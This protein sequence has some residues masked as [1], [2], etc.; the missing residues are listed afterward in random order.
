MEVP[1]QFEKSEKTVLLFWRLLDDGVKKYL[2]KS[3]RSLSVG[4]GFDPAIFVSDGQG[5]FWT[6]TR[7]HF[8]SGDGT[9]PL[10]GREQTC[11]FHFTQGANRLEN[12]FKDANAEVLG[13]QFKT[14]ALDCIDTLDV[15][16]TIEKFNRYACQTAACL[17]M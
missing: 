13:K 8:G 7:K 12:A 6:G 9:V 11:L 1:K 4:E 14:D 10:E 16:L 15:E 5:S 17:S 2:A 3:G